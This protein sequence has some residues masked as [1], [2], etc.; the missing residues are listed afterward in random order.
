MKGRDSLA[1]V[2]ES[3]APALEVESLTKRYDGATVLHGVSFTVPRGQVCGYLGPNGAGKSTTIKLLAGV[4]RPDGGSVR[5]AGHDVA[6]DPIEAK[7]A[8]GYVPESGA[9]YTL[10]TPRE[11]MSLVADLYDIPEPLAAERIETALERFDLKKLQ[12]RR[13]DTLSKGQ[14]Q[15]TLIAASL[16]HEP[17]VLLLDEPLNGLDVAAARA[18][19]DVVR[20]MAD[21]GATVLYCSH[22]L[23]VVERVCDRVIILDRGRIAADAPTAELVARGKDATLESV[24][25]ALVTSNEVEGLAGAF[26]DSKAAG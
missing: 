14:K 11:H 3:E 13:I 15:K 20:G 18:L 17:K 1:A 25:H 16:L 12:N 26:S 19:K 9:L 2:N 22:I 24:F 6:T 10:L 7:R 23:D 8:L 21:R 5:I 4:L